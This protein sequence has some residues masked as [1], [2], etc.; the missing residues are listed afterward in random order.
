MAPPVLPFSLRPFDD[1]TTPLALA[2][3]GQV[4]REGGQLRLRYRLAGAIDAV[5]LPSPAPSPARRDGLWS[6][7]CFECFWA[8][9]G[10][11]PYWEFNLS[12][13]GHWNLYRLA[14]YRQDLRPED[15]VDRPIPRLL[16]NDGSLALEV[17]LPLP[18][19]I[20]AGAPLQ[21]AITAVIE[22]RH[23]QVSYW[24]LGH[25]GAEPD[26]HDRRGFLLRL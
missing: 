21:V 4:S 25:P 26:F 20:P 2:F 24:A 5:R 7:T 3:G 8:I 15:G 19:A 23:G 12:P 6:T 17:D 14:D 13:A 1:A 10:E 22:D 18:P 9:A 11:R 16:R